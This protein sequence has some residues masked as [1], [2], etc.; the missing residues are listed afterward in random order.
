MQLTYNVWRRALAVSGVTLFALAPVISDRIHH[1]LKWVRCGFYQALVQYLRIM[2][3]TYDM[4]HQET[5][6]TGD[7]P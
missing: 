1:L 4:N 5:L 6:I 3:R 2:I 7:V